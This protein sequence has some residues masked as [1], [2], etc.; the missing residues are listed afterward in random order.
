MK[1]L[2]QPYP[3]DLMEMVPVSPLVNSPKVDTPEIITPLKTD[4]DEY[5]K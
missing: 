4:T 3:P 5:A 1:S 2:Y